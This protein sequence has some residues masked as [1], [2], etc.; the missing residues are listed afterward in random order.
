[1]HGK[2]ELAMTAAERTAFVAEYFGSC[3]SPPPGVPELL[4]A[5]P[6]LFPLPGVVDVTPDVGRFAVHQT[7]AHTNLV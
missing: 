5:N 7:H 6:A 1:M 4:T 2:Q 3:D